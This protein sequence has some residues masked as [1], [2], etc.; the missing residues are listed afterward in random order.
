MLS[1]GSWFDLCSFLKISP[2]SFLLGY[3]DE[4][5]PECI[6]LEKQ[7]QDIFRLPKEYA[8]S[9]GTTVRGLRGLVEFAKT[10]LGSKKW[11]S[12]LDRKG[13]DPDFFTVLTNQINMQFTYDLISELLARGVSEKELVLKLN[14]P[15]SLPDFHGSLGQY[16]VTQS[17]SPREFLQ[18]LI[19]KLNCY[20][21]NFSDSLQFGENGI[22]L[23]SKPAPF[24]AA[25]NTTPE[26]THSLCE[27]KV[28]FLESSLKIAT[29]DKIKV[30]H[31]HCF[32]EGESECKYL[33]AA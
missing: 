10:F 16:L 29:K 30:K 18:A 8:F 31:E 11:N 14:Q 13:V 25:F 1:T 4:Q 28:T 32:F 6:H 17:K 9:T 19:G 33:I 5:E 24:L 21:V 15:Y 22:E 26:V 12:Y 20:Q 27:A 23:T 3:I 7:Q 2:H